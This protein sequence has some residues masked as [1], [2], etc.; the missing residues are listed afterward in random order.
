MVVKKRIKARLP[1]PT[2]TGGVI[3]PKKGKGAKQPRQQP[4]YSMYRFPT[5]GIQMGD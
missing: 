3:R 5:F 1:L 2:K 4:D